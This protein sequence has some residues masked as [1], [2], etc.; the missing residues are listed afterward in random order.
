VVFSIVDGKNKIAG[1]LCRLYGAM[2][3]LLLPFRDPENGKTRCGATPERVCNAIQ[4][5]AL[6]AVKN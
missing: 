3:I 2:L 1:L 4:S 6:S 5:A